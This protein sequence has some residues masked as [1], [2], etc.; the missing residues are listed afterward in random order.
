MNFVTRATFLNLFFTGLITSQLHAQIPDSAKLSGVS[1]TG[2]SVGIEVSFVP[3]SFD[4]GLTDE[5]RNAIQTSGWWSDQELSDSLAQ[6]LIRFLNENTPEA[7]DDFTENTNLL[8]TYSLAKRR[9]AT[10]ITADII[11]WDWSITSWSLTPNVTIDPADI[12]YSYFG[13]I[14]W[15]IP[16]GGPLPPTEPTVLKVTKTSFVSDDGGTSSFFDSVSGARAGY[17]YQLS[18]SLDLKEFVDVGEP[19]EQPLWDDSG[20]IVL[21]HQ[22]PKGSMDAAFFRVTKTVQAE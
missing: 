14:H 17:S 9:S 12:S 15:V 8:V 11:A 19:T 10:G 18:R 1:S 20:I 5:Q 2:A 21:S 7:N 3:G 6:D 4:Q 13:N 16:T 22:F